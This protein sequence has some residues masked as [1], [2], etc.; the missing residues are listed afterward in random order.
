M[1]QVI[2]MSAPPDV[3]ADCGEA[4]RLQRRRDAARATEQLDENEAP[5]QPPLADGLAEGSQHVGPHGPHC[6]SRPRRRL[7][8]QLPATA[9]LGRSPDRPARAAGGWERSGCGRPSRSPSLSIANL[10]PT[11]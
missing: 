11:G 7:R 9:R 8:P 6:R 1:H 10:A 4:I 2:L 5:V 3:E